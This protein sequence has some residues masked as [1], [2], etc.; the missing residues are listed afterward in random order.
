MIGR[1]C[2]IDIESNETVR[3]LKEMIQEEM[4][5]ECDEQRLV[6][7]GRTL[8]DN[9]RIS[10]YNLTEESTIYITIRLNGKKMKN[11]LKFHDE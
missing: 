3:R 4:G 2:T 9:Q 11:F 7:T 10:D 5:F 1:T 6:V 8:E